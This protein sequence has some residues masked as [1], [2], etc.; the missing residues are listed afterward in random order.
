MVRAREGHAQVNMNMLIKLIEIRQSSTATR[1]TSKEK[2]KYHLA[3]IYVN[4]AH[5]VC[6]REDNTFKKKLLSEGI[7]P[8]GLDSRQS[9]TRI[10]LARGHSGIDVIIVDSIQSVQ[11]KLGLNGGKNV[12]RG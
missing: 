1:F 7:Y 11:K 10:N 6:M 12:L 8:D 5:V 3:E 4:P 9:F 2:Q